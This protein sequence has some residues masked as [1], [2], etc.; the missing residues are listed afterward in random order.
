MAKSAPSL[1]ARRAFF[2]RP[3]RRQHRRAERLGEHDRRGADAGRAAVDQKRLA[4]L[5]PAA[6]EHVGPH[7]EKRLGHRTRLDERETVGQRQRV[8][9][10]HRA[11]FR[12]AAARHQA[13]DAVAEPKARRTLA[14]PDHRAGDLEAGNVGCARRR[15]IGPL[16]LQDVG[17]VDAGRLDLDQHLARPRPG[18]RP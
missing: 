16:A 12:V 2:V 4:C 3:G 5:Q 11:E 1:H 18:G 15:R 13:A 10:M 9:L 6:L 7:G 14:Q 17:A 8:R